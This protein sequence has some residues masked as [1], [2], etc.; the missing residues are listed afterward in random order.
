MLWR[1]EPINDKNVEYLI[2]RDTD[3]RIQPREVMAVQEWID[4]EKSFI[5]ENKIKYP[6]GNFHTQDILDY[7]NF[8]SIPSEPALE[9]K[10]TLTRFP[11]LL[12]SF[13]TPFTS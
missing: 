13:V 3:T 12:F 2:S 6:D 9:I 5:T 7:E 8:K 11:S 4:S 1:I 10:I